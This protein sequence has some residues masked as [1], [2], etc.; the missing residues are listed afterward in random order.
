MD[1]FWHRRDLRVADNVGLS[2]AA[3]HGPIVPC[4]VLDDAVL[5]YAGP[6]RVRYLLASLAE[7]RDAYRER[8]SDLIVGRGDPAEII[9]QLAAAL[10]A[11]RAVW[12]RG[13]SGLARERDARVEESLAASLGAESP[14]VETHHDAVLHD[15]D[16]IRTNKGDPYSVFTYYW[17]KWRDRDKAPPASTPS[18]GDLLDAERLR[19]VVDDIAADLDADDTTISVGTLPTIAD[20]GFA[21]P[22]ADPISAGTAGARDRLSSFVEAD[23]FRYE[24]LRDVPAASATS[25]LSQDLSF[26]T[27]GPREVYAATEDAMERA[28]AGDADDAVADLE[29]GDADSEEVDPVSSVR[30]FRSQLAW[31][32]FYL[33]VLFHNPGTVSR[34]YKSYEHP[35]DW[36]DDPDTLAAWKR[37]ET[38]YPI[39]DAGMRQLRTEAD[40]HNRV[41]MIVAS[42]LTKDLLVDWREGYAHFR[43]HLRDHDTANDVGGWQWAASTGTD[44]QPYF[45]IFNPMTQGERYD[46][47]AGYIT[48]H[49]PEL[50][51]VD[52]DLIHDWHELDPDRREAVAP[53]YPAPIVDHAERREDA[54]ATFEAARGEADDG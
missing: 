36:R 47:D 50:R 49:V 45:R 37:G 10:G 20:L 16:S 5:E 35:I 52:P 23:I 14:D 53:A 6:P 1:L 29:G 3:D 43:E 32:E 22:E 17:K 46:P 15:P 12:N 42:F 51:G 25:D 28:A 33:Q 11:D 54:L 41:R 48:T 21:E 18:S 38:G 44:A 30:E 13:Y 34:N 2:A 39:V 19:A 7:L 24:A 31:R 8:G 26:G 27:I 9:P 40:M 4:F